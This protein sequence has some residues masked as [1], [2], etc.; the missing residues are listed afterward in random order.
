[1]A[2][3]KNSGATHGGCKPKSCSASVGLACL[4]TSPLWFIAVSS[5]L[6]I[7]VF[8]LCSSSTCICDACCNL[9]DG[10]ACVG[11]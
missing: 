8:L 6:F 5:F 9:V 3:G 7:A 1:M 11:C 2:I 10:G 4:N